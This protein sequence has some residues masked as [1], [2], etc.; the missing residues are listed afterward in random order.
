[1]CEQVVFMGPQACQNISSIFKHCV[2]GCLY[3]RE[4][5][6]SDETVN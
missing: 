4:D 5:G 2:D 3:M 6:N 1:M